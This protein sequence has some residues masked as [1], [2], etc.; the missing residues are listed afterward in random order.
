MG[1]FDNAASKLTDSK[2]KRY[3]KTAASTAYS[4]LRLVILLSIGFI[5][6]YPLFYMIVTSVQ[7]KDAFYDST[8]VWVPTQFNIKENYERAFQALKYGSS[9]WNTFLYAIISAGLEICSCAF[10]AYGFARFKFKG[11]GIL[12]FLLI[13][14]ILVPDMLLLIPRMLNFSRLDFLG[15]LGLVGDLFGTELRP[16][17]VDTPWVFWLPSILGVGLRSGVLIYIYIQFFRGLPH[18]L[19]EAAYVDG[20]SHF[21]TF[22]SIAIPSSGVVILTVTVFSLIWH[23]NDFLLSGMYLTENFPLAMELNMLKET[24]M[25]MFNINATA[26]NP[27]AQAYMMAGC[28]LFITPMLIVYMILQKWFIESIDRVGITG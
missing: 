21:R 14:S 13:V 23:W 3:G 11:K 22:I 4:I 8:R 26:R 6:I 5:I 1:L 15:I 17:V 16:N 2:Y 24:I 28:V 12:E 10:I 9:F 19:E 20:A 27:Q 25:L 18:E 7:S